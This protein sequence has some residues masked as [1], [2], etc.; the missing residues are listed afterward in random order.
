[1]NLFVLIYTSLR[2]LFLELTFISSFSVELK[3][4]FITLQIFFNHF[5]WCN[6]YK[7]NIFVIKLSTMVQFKMYHGA[8]RLLKGRM[9]LVLFFEKQWRWT[10]RILKNQIAISPTSRK[11]GIQL[12]IILKQNLSVLLNCCFPLLEPILVGNFFSSTI[13]YPEKKVSYMLEK[14]VFNPK[15]LVVFSSVGLLRSLWFLWLFLN[16]CLWNLKMSLSISPPSKI[17]KSS[18]LYTLNH[19]E[20]TL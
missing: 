17:C 14:A 10:L 2:I 9:C 5:L 16:V 4:N 13:V 15:S 3:S 18:I 12:F 8:V 11:F 7:C 19:S 1:M 6:N 20:Y